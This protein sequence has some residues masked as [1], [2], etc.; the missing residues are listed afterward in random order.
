MESLAVRAGAE[1]ANQA[2]EFLQNVTEEA[3]IQAAMM[4]EAADEH[5]L[6]RRWFDSDAWGAASI[7]RQLDSFL[8]K[9]RY[10]FIVPP[11]SPSGKA[12]C[13]NHGFVQ[14]AIQMLSHPMW[15]VC[16]VHNVSWVVQTVS[17]EI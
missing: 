9:L 4:A 16:A 7:G 13:E 15:L 2:N 14:Y 8:N 12:G 11:G 10:L 17:P 6:L 1:P 3:V 5:L